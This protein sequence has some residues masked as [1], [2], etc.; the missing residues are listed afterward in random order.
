[1]IPAELAQES[2]FSAD[3]MPTDLIAAIQ[4]QH[5]HVAERIVATWGDSLCVSYM[6]DLMLPSRYGRQGFNEAV[7]KA[8]MELIDLHDELHP[9][10]SDVWDIR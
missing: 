8:L 2:D 4:Y 5:P 6:T 10:N 7:A 1:M 3:Q 9:P